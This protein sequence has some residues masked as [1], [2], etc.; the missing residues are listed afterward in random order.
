[1]VGIC[2]HETIVTSNTGM[3]LSSLENLTYQFIRYS[4]SAIVAPDSRFCCLSRQVGKS[5]EISRPTSSLRLAFSSSNCDAQ[6]V[7]HVL[8]PPSFS[9]LLSIPSYLRQCCKRRQ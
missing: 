1:M 4:A 6:A 3:N 8:H 2:R 7:H 9:S 5:F